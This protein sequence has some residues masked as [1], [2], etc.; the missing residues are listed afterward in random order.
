MRGFFSGESL[1]GVDKPHRYF[2]R[3]IFRIGTIAG[4]ILQKRILEEEMGGISQEVSKSELTECMDSA[5]GE[6]KHSS[7]FGA[8]G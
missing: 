2:F 8:T 6:R 1:S 3:I 4:N 5:T 7:V